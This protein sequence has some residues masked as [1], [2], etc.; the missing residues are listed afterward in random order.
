MMGKLNR[1]KDATPHSRIRSALRQVWLR[2]RERAAALKSAGH[3]CERCGVKGRAKDTRNGP[4]QVLNVHHKDGIDW[5]GLTE[6]IARRILHH[7]D[8]LEVLC[9][10][11]HDKEHAE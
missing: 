5:D 6:L 4:R 9:P 1:R 2:S 7:P 3:S 8:R 11:C 10:E